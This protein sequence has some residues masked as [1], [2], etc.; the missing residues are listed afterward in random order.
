MR[1]GCEIRDVR[2]DGA[3]HF[4]DKR[5]LDNALRCRYKMCRKGTRY[6][7]LKCDMPLCP[8]AWQASTHKKD[9]HQRN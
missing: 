2:L 3:G 4:P 6:F 5:D 1:S 8:K 7:C 9:D